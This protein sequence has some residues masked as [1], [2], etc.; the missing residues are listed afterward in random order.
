MVLR[1]TKPHLSVTNGGEIEGP[2][3]D[4]FQGKSAEAVDHWAFLG[5]I[6]A[7]MWADLSSEANFTYQ[8]KDDDWF[9]ISHP[10]HRC[11][12]RQLIS[13]FSHSG[14]GCTNLTL[15]IQG[16][17]SPKLPSSV[18]R[19]RGKHYK[20]KEW[21]QSK[22]HPVKK[23]VGKSSW[24]S[25]GSSNETTRKSRNEK[26]HGPGSKA[27]SVCESSL[28]ETSGPKYPKVSSF[29]DSKIHSDNLTSTSTS[30]SH[31]E[32]KSIEVSSQIF[33]H[34]SGL[35]SALK[36]SLRKSCVTRLASRVEKND[37]RKSEGCK[38]SSGKSSV[39]SSS[40]PS[41][42]SKNLALRA[43][44]NKDET[45]DS[46]NA[47]RISRAPKKI[48][49][50]TNL[51]KVPGTRVLD[52][53]SNSRFERVTVASESLNQEPTRAKVQRQTVRGRVL[54]PQRVNQQ[55]QLP[56]TK[57]KEKEGLG[58]Y[59]RIADG[60]KENAKGLSA[61]SQRY[62]TREKLARD[63][64]P[65]QKSSKQSVAQKNDRKKVVGPKEKT[66]GQIKGKNHT[67]VVQKVCFR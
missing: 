58:R 59:S 40:N 51:S 1:N 61:M 11:S 49:R 53:T 14:E 47:T 5:E 62:N 25:S 10:F 15:G 2:R 46:R 29:G 22:Q 45:P 16:P 60:A 67:N 21:A 12:S 13:A 35:L 42:G 36:V 30:A 48:V 28:N 6:E 55:E 32:Q 50:D 43:T 64:V 41:Y 31:G 65:V 17:S 38:Y 44:R 19:S 9:H 24:A 7:P 3:V 20:S 54:V 63:M 27:G 57:G 8:D 37:A 18:S 34:S 52:T 56:T 4:V 26:S 33:A 23:L 66:N 39:G